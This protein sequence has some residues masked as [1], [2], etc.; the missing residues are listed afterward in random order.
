MTIK[1][2]AQPKSEAEYA[3]SFAEIAP[4][5]TSDEAAAESSRCLYCYDAPCIKACPTEIDIPSFIK[6]ISTQNVR[7][8]ARVIFDAN[9]M[10]ASCARGCP[11]EV[12]CEGA[13]VMNALQRRPIEIGRLQRFAT[14]HVMDRGVTLF[15]AGPPTGKKVAIVGAG[16]G[17]LSAAQV[18]R[19]HGHAVTLIEARQKLGGLNTFGIAQY[20]MR[21]ETALAEAERIVA[22][23]VT[24]KLGT[25]VG[26]DVSFADLERDFDAVF[27]A[28]GLGGTQRLGI[29]GESLE[30]VVDA[31]T[32]IEALKSQPYARVPVGRKV[33][34][35]GA[36]NTSID[37]AT[38]AKRLGADRVT[39][40][41]RRGEA[42][43]SAYDHEYELA[44][45]D[46]VEF[47][48]FTQPVAVKGE[49]AVT[50]L[51]CLRTEAGKPIAGTEHTIDCDMV[52]YAIGQIKR[53]ELVSTIPGATFDKGKVIVDPATFRTTNPKFWAGG[54]CVNGGAEIVNAAAE[55]KRAAGSIH[56]VLSGRS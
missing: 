54:D 30:G 2:R 3:A 49:G 12:L 8:A 50:G 17:G 27:V 36:G 56:A 5:L 43:M 9:P 47:R 45:Q 53:A 22:L 35:V 6:K 34:V 16:P 32:F 18:L 14:D 51:E 4:A 46:G 44:K 52:I 29:P 48:F 28:V 13:C 15:E 42:D 39:I 10:G 11:V 20:K 25:T 55:G 31:I 26:V 33:I 24:L 7:G 40:V 21:P 19:R 38:Q 23:G 1:E 37:A 41:Y